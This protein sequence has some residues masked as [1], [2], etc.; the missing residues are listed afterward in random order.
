MPT[1]ALIAQVDWLS[2]EILTLTAT[3]N[4]MRIEHE[5]VVANLYQEIDM[6]KR[7]SAPWSRRN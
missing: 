1:S 5:R 6:L 2:K 7:A 4:R 3:T